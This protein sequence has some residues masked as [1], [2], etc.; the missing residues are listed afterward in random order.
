MGKK[1]NLIGERFG[2]LLV[3]NTAPNRGAKT[4]YLCKCD[5]GNMTEVSTN[6]LRKGEII[7]CGCYLRDFIN[8]KKAQSVR[9]T[10]LYRCWQSIKSRCFNPNAKAYKWY[11][12]RGITMCGEW[13][14]SFHSFRDW[15]FANGYA[16]NLEI[17]RIDNDG[18][19]SP[20]NCRWVTHKENCNNRIRK[21]QGSLADGVCEENGGAENA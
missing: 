2:R 8:K 18:N 1:L 16:E 11:G 6:S 10:R 12:A 17:D 3:V 19:Y 5:C 15:S 20:D 21:T 13:V 4:Y 14:N 9:N 7:S